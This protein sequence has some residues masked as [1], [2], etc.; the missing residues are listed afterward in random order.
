MR[1]RCAP[2]RFTFDR[3]HGYWGAKKLAKTVIKALLFSPTSQYDYRYIHALMLDRAHGTLEG[4]IPND[5][6]LF[7]A[8]LHD[9][10]NISIGEELSGPYREQFLEAMKKEVHELEG[11]KTWKVMERSSLPEGANISKNV[12]RWKG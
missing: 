1:T 7:K 12:F 4:A 9:P 11:H 5:P 6:F 3:K 10:D 8:N 2:E